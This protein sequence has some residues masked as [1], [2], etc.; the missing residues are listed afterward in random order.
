MGLLPEREPVDL[1]VERP[2]EISPL[3]I[4][5]KEVVTPVAS[6]FKAQVV[7]NQGNNIITAKED[8]K[9]Q[10]VVPAVSQEYLEEGLKKGS[11]ED[12][13]TWVLGYWLRIIKKSII[14]GWNLVFKQQA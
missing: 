3:T 9:Y 1:V 10:V 2:D 4:E 7:D 5:R 11:I 6:S 8:E 13:N 12:S 14:N